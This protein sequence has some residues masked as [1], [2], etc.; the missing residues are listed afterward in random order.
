MCSSCT[1][2]AKGC[3]INHDKQALR[4]DPLSQACDQLDICTDK[5]KRVGMPTWGYLRH[6]PPAQILAVPV[7]VDLG[8]GVSHAL[9]CPGLD[10]AVARPPGDAAVPSCA[11]PWVWC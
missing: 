5:L 10:P 11:S 7:L 8:Q 9:L 6:R 2:W 1:L 3:Y 4:P